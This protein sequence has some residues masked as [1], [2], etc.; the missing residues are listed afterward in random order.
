MN[1]VVSL[2]A[3]LC[4]VVELLFLPAKTYFAGFLDVIGC[5]ISWSVLIYV[6]KIVS[7][8]KTEKL[9]EHYVTPKIF[10]GTSKQHLTRNEG[11]RCLPASA[12]RDLSHYELDFLLMPF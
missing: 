7:F 12:L 4:L 10:A 9:L 2:E 5:F 3:S 11:F 8:L 1:Q 6:Q